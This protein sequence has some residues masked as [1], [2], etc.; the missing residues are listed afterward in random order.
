MCGIC[1]I[2]TFDKNTSQSALMSAVH[3]QMSLMEKRG[4]DAEGSLQDPGGHLYSGFRRL[5]ILD[6]TQSGNQPMVSSD[7]RSTIV[8]NGE[9]YNYKEIRHQLKSK[10]VRFRSRSDTEVLLEALNF[11]GVE[12]L[13]KLNGMFAFA[14]YDRREETLLL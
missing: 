6:L 14:W 3:H 8:F 13:N 11:W 9:I 5:A 7:G 10:G 4:P 1:G 2:L 12:A